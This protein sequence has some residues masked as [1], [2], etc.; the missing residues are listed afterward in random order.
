ME[1]QNVEMKPLHCIIICIFY[2]P[3]AIIV[4]IS[5]FLDLSLPL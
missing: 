1:V 3:E 5:A 4:E 2:I